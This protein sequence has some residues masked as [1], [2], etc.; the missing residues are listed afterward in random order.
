MNTGSHGRVKRSGSGSCSDEA[1]DIDALEV[2]LRS[3][4][5][6][7]ARVESDTRL[8]RQALLLQLALKALDWV[9]ADYCWGTGQRD[10]SYSALAQ[11]LDRRE[12]GAQ[13]EPAP[14]RSE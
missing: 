9:I 5:V 4:K 6:S 10:P 3:G 7:R 2:M 13:P 12:S 1:A 8:V 14:A 11:Y